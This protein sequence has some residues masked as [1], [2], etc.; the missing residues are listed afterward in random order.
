[1]PKK[2]EWLD[3]PE[4]HD[5][6]AALSCLSLPFPVKR[7]ADLVH[8]LRAAPIEHWKA[9]DI[10]RMSGEEKLDERNSHVAHNLKKIDN[11]KKL[12]PVLLVRTGEKLLIADGYHRVCTVYLHDE[13]AL[14]PAKIAG[15]GA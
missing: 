7:A 5:Y 12:S 9:K 2:I 11:G 14:I 10:L 6:T 13:D 1:M 4:Q 8:E 15:T 3:E